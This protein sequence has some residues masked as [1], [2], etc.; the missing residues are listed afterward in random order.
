MAPLVGE[1]EQQQ[2]VLG[3]PWHL[4]PCGSCAE[5]DTAPPQQCPACS[6]PMMQRGRSGAVF[7]ASPVQRTAWASGEPQHR[8]QRQRVPGLTSPGDLARPPRALEAPACPCPIYL[9]AVYIY[10]LWQE[11]AG[12]RSTQP[13]QDARPCSWLPFLASPSPSLQQ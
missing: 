10:L 11:S 3:E 8:A 13:P 7:P 5:L 2:Q 6:Q 9:Y 12:P 1:A 4:L